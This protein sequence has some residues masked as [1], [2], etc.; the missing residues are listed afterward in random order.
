MPS[1]MRSVAGYAAV[2]ALDRIV[3]I[4]HSRTRVFVARKA[5]LI[6]RFYQQRRRFSGMRVMAFQALPVLERL[7]LYIT[8]YEE[9]FGIVAIGAEARTLGGGFEYIVS[10][11]GIVA[12]LTFTSEHWIMDTRLQQGG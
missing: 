5:K 4:L 3:D 9:V 11:S 8:G 12:G 2:V 1:R 10:V 7:V 6:A